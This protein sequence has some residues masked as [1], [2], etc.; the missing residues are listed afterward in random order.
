MGIIELWMPIVGSAI[1]VFVVSAIVW[2]A[3][4]WHKTDFR[5][6]SNEEGARSA[7]SGLEPGLY[8]VP[9]CIDPK[10]LENEEVANKYKEGPNAYITVVPSGLPQMGPKLLMSFVYYLFVGCICAYVVSRT[11]GAGGDYLG[12]F[13]IAGTTAWIAY[14]IA[15]IQDSVWFGRPWSLTIKSLFDALLYALV[16]G[17]MFGWLAV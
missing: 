14:G 10:E 1:A 7:M 2:M 15:Y 4:P 12:V 16:T 13:R 3:M 5:K 17:G 8:M 11:V 6:L 9:Y